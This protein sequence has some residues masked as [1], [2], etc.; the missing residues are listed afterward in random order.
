MGQPDRV[1]PATRPLKLEN[2]PYDFDAA[3][4]MLA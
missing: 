2:P 3:F 1:L 4:Q